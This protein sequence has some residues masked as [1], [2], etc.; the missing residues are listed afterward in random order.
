[1]VAAFEDSYRA[2]HLVEAVL[3]SARRDGIWTKVVE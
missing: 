2:N 1:V 3:E